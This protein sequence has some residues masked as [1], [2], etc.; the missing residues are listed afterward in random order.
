MISTFVTHFSQNTRETWDGK[1][2]WDTSEGEVNKVVILFV[3]IYSESNLDFYTPPFVLSQNIRNRTHGIRHFPMDP[4]PILSEAVNLKMYSHPT[5]PRAPRRVLIISLVAVYS[6][7]LLLWDSKFKKNSL[8]FK[9]Q[10]FSGSVTSETTVF[11]LFF[12]FSNPDNL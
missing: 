9:I 6:Y 7:Y 5:S 12:F 4:L 3:N 10:Q 11:C 8:K 2:P 1:P